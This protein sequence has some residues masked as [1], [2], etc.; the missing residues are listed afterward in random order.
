MLFIVFNILKRIYKDA[1]SCIY[2]EDQYNWW[3][4]ERISTEHH[5]CYCRRDLT[6][7]CIMRRG[8]SMPIRAISVP[9]L[10]AL[11]SG[12]LGTARLVCISLRW[13]RKPKTKKRFSKIILPPVL[14]III[15]RSYCYTVWSAIS[16][17]SVRP[18]VCLS[19][20]L[21]IVAINGVGVQ[22]GLKVVPACSYM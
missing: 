7:L 22:P 1:E 13:Q 17:T 10:Y 15:S 6:I 11:V 14:T 12:P 21:R 3:I 4:I 16:V 9:P 19:V 5:A 2:N 8:T 18:S 20:T